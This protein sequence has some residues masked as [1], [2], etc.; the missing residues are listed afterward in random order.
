M[1]QLESSTGPSVTAHAHSPEILREVYRVGTLTN[2]KLDYNKGPSSWLH[3]NGVV[4][5]D[6]TVQLIT[7]IN[8]RWR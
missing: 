5:N 2:L 8:G 6:G 4:H 7:S 3:T 1:Y